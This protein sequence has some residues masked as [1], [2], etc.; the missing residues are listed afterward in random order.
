MDMMPARTYAFMSNKGGVGKTHIAVNLAIK[1]AREGRR[2]LLVDA[3]LGNANVHL[4]VGV[5][6]RIT[7]QDFFED[8][9]AMDLCIT[10]TGYGVDFLPGSSGD[11]RIANLTSEQIINL[12]I[13]FEGLVRSG[14]YT[15]IFFDLGAGISIRVT[16]LALVV[17]ELIIVTTPNN[18]TSAYSAWKACW[19]RHQDL[20]TKRYFRD[21]LSPALPQKFID[22]DSSSGLRVNFIVNQADNLQEGKQMYLKI[23]RVGRDFFYTDEGYWMMPVRYIGGI[24]YIPGMLRIAEREMTPAIIKFPHDPFTK[25]IGEIS[26][27]L[28]A[29]QIFAPD[30]LQMTFTERIRNVMSRIARA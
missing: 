13:A 26:N 10:G 25:A 4:R 23:L 21:R 6:P 27:M 11:L 14:R 5:S 20:S 29:K 30:K 16:D 8:R 3:D 19:L 18:I 9:A 2:V 22:G 15:D 28:L 7:L 12:L 17:D 1:F 24:P